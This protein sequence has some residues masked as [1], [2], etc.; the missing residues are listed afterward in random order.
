M[1]I[2][3]LKI[4]DN[5]ILASII[6]NTFTEHHAPKCGTVFSDPTTDDL[7]TLFKQENSMLWVAEDQGEVLGCCGIYPTEGLPEGYAELVKFY[8]LPSAR[9]KGVGTKLMQQNIE[10]AKALGFHHIYLESLPHFA[11]A[12]RMYKRFDFHPLD[13]PLGQSGHTSCN[14]WMVKTI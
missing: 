8:L 10:S 3:Q 1:I 12:V 2:R 4:S 6:K 7:F 9:G 14:I 13:K 11:T 5:P